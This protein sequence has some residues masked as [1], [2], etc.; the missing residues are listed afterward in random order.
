MKAPVKPFLKGVLA[1]SDK[2]T[3]AG[4]EIT[5]EQDCDASNPR[6]EYD[7]FGKLICF[8]KRYSLGDKSDY[9]HSDFNSWAALQAQIE[10]D[11][12]VAV[13]LPVYMYDHS[14]ITI[15]TS[16]FSCPWDS[17]QIGFIFCTVKQ[18]AEEF[19]GDNER[20]KNLLISEIK[21]YDQFLTGDVWCFAIRKADDDEVL[22]SCCGFFGHD[23]CVNEAKSCADALRKYEDKNK[24]DEEQAALSLF[25]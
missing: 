15:S 3:H 19:S 25:N 24:I 23:Y 14:G 2:I 12:D 4:F 11:N 21:T 22:E 7:N 9:R 10:E 16:P 18:V 13:L 20:A 1:M 8:H 5:I 17:G 6:E